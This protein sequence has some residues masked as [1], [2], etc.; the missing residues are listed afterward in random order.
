MGAEVSSLNSWP[1]FTLDL[2]CVCNSSS[3]WQKAKDIGYS[4]RPSVD[5]TTTT[6]PDIDGYSDCQAKMNKKSSSKVTSHLCWVCARARVCVGEDNRH[7]TGVRSAE[8]A[9]RDQMRGAPSSRDLNEHTGRKSSLPGLEQAPNC[10]Q[11][12]TGTRQ[13]L[14]VMHSKMIDS[15][16]AVATTSQF[17]WLTLFFSFLFGH[18]GMA[19]FI[20]S[21]SPGGHW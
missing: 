18:S 15:S 4:H 17:C 6:L 14:P 21:L 10:R 9:A 7:L 20:L 16:T 3:V 19:W 11:T 1:Q 5:Y 13:S 2:P 8:Q 12:G